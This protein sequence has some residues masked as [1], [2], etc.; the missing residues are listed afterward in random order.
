MEHPVWSWDASWR[1][2]FKEES[3][4][5]LSSLSGFMIGCC[6]S[7]FF[8]C[9]WQL[10]EVL[11]VEIVGCLVSFGIV[12]FGV[13]WGYRTGDK[14]RGASGANAK[15]QLAQGKRGEIRYSFHFSRNSEWYLGA[16]IGILKSDGMPEILEIKGEGLVSVD[17][18]IPRLGI[19]LA[20]PYIRAT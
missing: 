15:A 11:A 8:L 16:R 13:F 18:S 2:S 9:S 10:A 6:N 1:T 12:L 5:E 14:R 17:S 7:Y 19:L 20:S 4:S 3:L